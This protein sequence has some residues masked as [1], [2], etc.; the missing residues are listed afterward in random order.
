VEDV[1]EA[2][3]LLALLAEPDRLKALA[4]VVLGAE[5]LPEVAER[6]GLPPRAAARALNRLAAGGLLDGDASK[7]YRVRSETLRAA[8]RRTASEPAG[9]DAALGDGPEAEVLRR[10]VRGGRL[11]SIPVA[12]AKRLLVLDHLAGLFEPGR[13]YLE[14]EVNEALRAYHP[15]YATLRRYLVD[16]GFLDRTDE[17]E[18]SGSR[19]VKL[20]W[21]SGGTIDVG[22]PSGA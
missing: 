16:E 6:A 13:R 2:R 15:D 22:R 20:Y 19:S 4:A 7:G 17:T 11:L 3:D 5:T 12:R 9:D 21:R 10:F 8:A 18:A 14:S 1:R